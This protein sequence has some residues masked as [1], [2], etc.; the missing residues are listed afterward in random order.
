MY[1]NS[2]IFANNRKFY[3][4]NTIVNYGLKKFN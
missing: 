3:S 4:K 2:T 1:F